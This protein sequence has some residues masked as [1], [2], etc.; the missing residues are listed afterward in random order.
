MAYSAS[1][2]FPAEYASKL[3]HMRLIKDPLVQKV[4]EAFESTEART[5]NQPP[6]EL[7]HASLDKPLSQIITVDGSSLDVPQ[8]QRVERK[9][10]FIQIAAQLFKLTTLEKLESDPMMDPREANRLINTAVQHLQATLPLAG[11][12]LPGQTVAQTIR[13]LTR[14][15]FRTY[16]LDQTLKDL[17]YRSWS[18]QWPP[19]AGAPH[20]VCIEANCGGDVVWQARH[21]D[22]QDCPKCGTRHF[23]SDYL[24]LVSDLG[25]DRPRSEVI[26]NFRS[27]TEALT[28]FTFIL[29]YREKQKILG[30][31]LFLL[32]GPLLLRANLSRLVEPI[33][34]LLQQQKD[35]GNPI[36]LAGVE[37]GGDFRAYASSISALLEKPG[38]YVLPSVQFLVE[39]INGNRF[40]P[41]T[42][43]NRVN[44]GAKIAARLGPQHVVAVNIPTGA[45]LLNPQPQDLAGVEQILS[46]LSRV[47]SS[48]HEN[49]LI[50]LVL[51]NQQASISIEPSATLLQ[52]FVD[53][54]LRGEQL[55]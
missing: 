48:A 28:L 22:F 55:V 44:Y 1:G 46:T 9:M 47:V 53:R 6:I 29:G 16:G 45:F 51:I 32:D 26:Q 13:G 11:V 2:G 33:R 42:Y 20:Q 38:D 50:P 24:D 14:T 36:H 4:I 37:K 12:H 40:N 35:K 8:L 21:A 43:V 52:N 23:I 18:A 41:T 30:N 15:F 54:L 49:A 27:V 31:T 19:S 7:R 25:E 34:D 10:G 3:G 5:D 39:Q 17:V